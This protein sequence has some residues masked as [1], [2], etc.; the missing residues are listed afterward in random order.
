MSFCAFFLLSI[1]LPCADVLG[2]IHDALIAFILTSDGLIVVNGFCKY[3]QINSF[4][5]VS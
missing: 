2:G 3:L 4:S 1:H 5:F